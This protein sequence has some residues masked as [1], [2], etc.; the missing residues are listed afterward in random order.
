MS[1][2]SPHVNE[3]TEPQKFPDSYV[4]KDSNVSVYISD[5][6]ELTEASK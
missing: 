6:P 4:W 1:C 3:G 2:R 5:I